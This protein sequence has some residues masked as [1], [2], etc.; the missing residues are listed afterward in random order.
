MARRRHARGMFRRFAGWGA[1]DRSHHAAF[2]ALMTGAAFAMLRAKGLAPTRLKNVVRLARS[3]HDLALDAEVPP[4]HVPRD[5]GALLP[6]V[7]GG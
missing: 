7:W 3:V 1:A 4:D 6:R 2:D 5:G